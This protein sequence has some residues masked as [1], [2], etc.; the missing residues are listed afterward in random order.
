MAYRFRQAATSEQLAGDRREV[1]GALPAGAETQP[2]VDWQQARDGSIWFIE[3]LSSV[4]VSFT[5]FALLAVAVIVGSVVAGSVLSSYR[6]IGIAKALGFTPAQV[7]AIYI[8]QMLAAGDIVSKECASGGAGCRT[9]VR[10]EAPPLSNARRAGLVRSHSPSTEQSFL[11]RVL[12]G[13]CTGTNGPAARPTSAPVVRPPPDAAGRPGRGA[14][15]PSPNAGEGGGHAAR[16]YG[17]RMP[18]S[19]GV[20]SGAV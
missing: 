9:T 1:E 16:C 4:I 7:L 12:S 18:P 10:T 3:L 6:D 5:V 8:G 17:L 11:A 2:V 14:P 13:P 19:A 15:P 20:G